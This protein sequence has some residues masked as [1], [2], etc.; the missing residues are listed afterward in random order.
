MLDIDL[1][2]V[3]LLRL[4]IDIPLHEK[5]DA[6]TLTGSLLVFR[7]VRNPCGNDRWFIFLAMC[8]VCALNSKCKSTMA[9]DK[10]KFS[11]GSH[12]IIVKKS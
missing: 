12:C 9:A 10:S 7:V 5:H 1:N 3:D 6:P 8:N 2:F 11:F 4:E